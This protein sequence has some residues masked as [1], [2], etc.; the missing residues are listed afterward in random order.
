MYQLVRRFSSRTE[1]RPVGSHRSRYPSGTSSAQMIDNYF[2]RKLGGEHK[3][4]KREQET[5]IW[6]SEKLFATYAAMVV[7]V[8]VG[9]GFRHYGSAYWGSS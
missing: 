3:S 7:P 6:K 5:Q 8:A 9:H 4:L 2:V 1:K